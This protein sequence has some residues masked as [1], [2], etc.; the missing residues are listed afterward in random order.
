MEKYMLTPY[1]TRYKSTTFNVLASPFLAK[2]NKKTH[3]NDQI[4]EKLLK[5]PDF[6]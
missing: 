4:F 6:C 1:V 2:Y 3:F 5:T